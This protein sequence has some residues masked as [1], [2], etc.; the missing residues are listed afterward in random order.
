MQYPVI[1]G[2]SLL[3]RAYQYRNIYDKEAL[4]HTLK[5]LLP[6]TSLTQIEKL[7]E[8]LL[9]AVKKQKRIIIIADYDCD[10]ATACAVMARMLMS[11]GANVG[12][13]VPDR[14]IHGYG[15]TP[16]IVDEAYQG[17][18]TADV[19]SLPKIEQFV[20]ENALAMVNNNLSLFQEVLKEE[21][22]NVLKTST[23]NQS[24]QR[25][26]VILTVDNGIASVEGVNHALSLGLEVLVTDHHLA[27]KTIPPAAA[28]VNPNHPDCRF[29]SKALCGVGVAWYVCAQFSK[30]AKQANIDTIDI[31]SL[32]PLV[33]LGTVADVVSL[34]ENNRILVNAGLEIFRHQKSIVGLEALV[35]VAGLKKERFSSVDIGFQV[36]PRINAAGR[37][38]N[39]GIGILNLVTQDP[40]VAYI[41]A[42]QLNHLN[43]VRKEITKH[44]TEEGEAIIQSSLNRDYSQDTVIVLYPSEDEE[45]HE[46]VIGIVA[47]RLKEKF[48]KPSIVMTYIEE[49]HLYKGSCRSIPSLHFKDL[50]D[51]VANEDGDIFAKYGGHAMA[52]GLSVHADKI[53]DFIRII[54]EK[55]SEKLN[56]AD[57]KKYKISDGMV[58]LSELSLSNVLAVQ[59]AVW[60][61]NFPYPQFHGT[62]TVVNTRR[63]GGN[64][65]HLK[66]TLRHNNYFVD[67]VRFNCPNWQVKENDEITIL[68]QPTINEW[69]DK[70][71][72]NLL[73]QEADFDVNEPIS[74]LDLHNIQAKIKEE[75]Q[76]TQAKNSLNF[77]EEDD[78]KPLKRT[79]NKQSND[80]TV[81]FFERKELKSNNL[82][83]FD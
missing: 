47:G 18:V 66:I 60:G 13:L 67:A 16:K 26:D 20:K 40:I 33:A 72:V 3:D 38:K 27:G 6:I 15:L 78:A 74:L 52:A 31:K 39:M 51:E 49:D 5:D 35:E 44:V 68:F 43:V 23:G 57:F 70:L 77:N 21:Q 71:S 50:L 82:P 83:D 59:Q 17:V 69:N 22:E 76:L 34:D 53:H 62:F 8:R 58:S 42:A 10:G 55:A 48:N 28:I 61:Q 64:E 81:Y 75:K 45:W 30:I 73:I 46:G 9:D 41:T 25:P 79:K 56:E 36:G 7:S 14:A 65:E 63:M 32:L 1:T 19:Q 4:S 24:S 37:I 54:N 29:I 12:W 80:S 2:N 11:A